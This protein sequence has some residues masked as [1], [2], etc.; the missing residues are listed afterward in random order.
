MCEKCGRDGRRETWRKTWRDEK[1]TGR[2]GREDWT[3]SGK[4]ELGCNGGWLGWV[5]TVAARREGEKGGK[6]EDGRL[7]GGWRRLGTRLILERGHV[8]RSQSNTLA[9]GREP[10]SGRMSAFGL[11]NRVTSRTVPWDP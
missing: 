9:E 8:S 2:G 10:W 7:K 11:G 1:E 3:Y 6:K 4:V 5:V